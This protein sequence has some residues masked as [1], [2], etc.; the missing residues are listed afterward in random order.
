MPGSEA[1]RACPSCSGLMR[2]G[3]WQDTLTY[4]GQSLTYAQ[5]GWVCEGC[6]DGILQGADNQVHDAT[7]HELVAQSKTRLDA[8][9]RRVYPDQQGSGQD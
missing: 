8:I 1:T 7:L 6:E 5:P 3:E 4:G 9:V 2:R